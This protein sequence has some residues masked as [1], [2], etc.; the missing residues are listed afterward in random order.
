[1]VFRQIVLFVA[2]ESYAE[3]EFIY[4]NEGNVIWSYLYTY[5]KV[6][7]LYYFADAFEHCLHFYLYMLFSSG[8]RDGFKQRV[9]K[10]L[11]R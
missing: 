6:W 9:S 2:N 1:M 5:W 7:R 8:F 4:D 10:I 3:E 11:N